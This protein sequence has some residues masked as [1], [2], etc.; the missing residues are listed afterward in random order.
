LVQETQ[1]RSPKGLACGRA[2]RAFL[3]YVENLVPFVAVSLALI[4]T[5]RTGGIGAIGAT[6]WIIGRIVYLAIYVLGINYV[7]TAAW[8]VSIIGLL[9]MLWRLAVH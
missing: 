1:V 5:Q 2:A 6:R 7:R 9:M 3:N 4:A 8:G